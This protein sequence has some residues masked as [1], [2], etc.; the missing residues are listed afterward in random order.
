MFITIRLILLII[1]FPFMNLYGQFSLYLEN[2]ILVETEKVTVLKMSKDGRFLAYGDKKGTLYIWDVDAKRKLHEL[3][4]HKK[5]INSL[6]FDTRNQRLI[7][8]SDDKKIIIWD[9]YSGKPEL[10]IEDFKSQVKCMDLSPDD[11]ILATGG[12]KKEIYLWEFPFGSL[13]G[14]LKS[15]KKDV[16]SLSFNINGDQLLSVGK[17]K[18][19]IVWDAGRQQLIRKTEIESKTIKNSGIDMLSANFSSDKYFVGIG[20]QE[21]VLAKGGRGMIFRYNLAFFDWKTGSEIEILEGNRKDINFFV[22]SPDKNYA[23]TDNSTLRENQIS[24]W[25]IQK[26]ISEQNYPIDGEISAIEISEDGNWLAVAYTEDKNYLKSFVNVWKLSGI[27]GFKRFDTDR[28]IVSSRKS[29]FG[30]AMKLNTPEEPLISFGERKKIAVMYLDNP[31]LDENTAK[32]TTYLLE[33]KL[34]NSPFVELIE[35][36]QI[37]T[38]V[39]ELKYQMS[40]LSTSNAVEVGKHLNAEYILMGSINKLG[41][42]LIIT[43]KL[44]N[45]ETAQIEGTRE[46]QCN[47]ATIENISDMVSLL[48][49]SIAKY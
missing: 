37:E 49:P 35:R 5:Q 8:G 25:N 20:I 32:T 45:V 9:L 18:L 1:I 19:M 30:S 11:R 10:I 7:S 40:G 36:N 12:N 28:N 21:H 17:D 14:K 22:I 15:H 6:I 43:V 24:F 3:K 47:N 38:V 4:L 34:G 16:I 42:L 26:G 39:A 23:I 2:K 31:G 41:N 44:V 13:K 33:G 27:E 48:A 46:V 29:G